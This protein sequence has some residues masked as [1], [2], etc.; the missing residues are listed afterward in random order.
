[1]DTEVVRIGPRSTYSDFSLL[2]DN[3]KNRTGEVQAFHASKVF[4]ADAFDD[5]LHF[6]D[7]GIVRRVGRQV[8]RV[9]DSDTQNRIDAIIDS[10]NI[11]FSGELHY[12]IDKRIFDSCYHYLLLGGENLV[13]LADRLRSSIPHTSFRDMLFRKGFPAIV[14]FKLDIALLSAQERSEMRDMAKEVIRSRNKLIAYEYSF[15][16]RK[17]VPRSDIL[18]IERVKAVANKYAVPIY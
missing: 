10:F 6:S 9:A 13:R 11:E 17:V 3:I 16:H 7:V 15:I 18:R 8:F 12:A 2:L 14:H 1:M 4:A 5:G